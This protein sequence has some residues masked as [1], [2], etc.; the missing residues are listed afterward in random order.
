MITHPEQARALLVA[1]PQLSYA[2]FQAL[3]LNKIVDPGILQVPRAPLRLS[4]LRLADIIS[5]ACSPRPGAACR[6]LPQ[7]RLRQHPHPWLPPTRTTRIK[8]HR[9]PYTRATRLRLHRR[10]A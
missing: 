1:H 5:S 4:R 8:V 6:T 7:L 3:L 10:T 2:L 9:H